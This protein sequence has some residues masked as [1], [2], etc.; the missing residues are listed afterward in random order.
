MSRIKEQNDFYFESKDASSG[1]LSDLKW[2]EGMP[3]LLSLAESV[4]TFVADALDEGAVAL[5]LPQSA[6]ALLVTEQLGWEATALL[7]ATDQHESQWLSLPEE[8]N[9]DG[10]GEGWTAGEG[11]GIWPDSWPLEGLK[12]TQDVQ[13]RRLDIPVTDKT[14]LTLLVITSDGKDKLRGL[15]WL[16][17]KV[18]VQ[19]VPLL[20]IW[21]HAR[22]LEGDLDQAQTQ[23]HALGRLNELQEKAVSLASHEFKTPL[24]SITAYS[25]AMR[26]Q[27]SNTEF[28]HAIE[29]LDVIRSEAGRLLRMVNRILDYSKM[30]AG[31]QLLPTQPLKICPLVEETLLALKPAAAAKKLHLDVKLPEGLP[32]VQGDDDLIRQVLIN[33]LGNAVKYTPAGGQVRVAAKENEATVAVTVL[34]TGVGIADQDLQK[35]FREFYRSRGRALSEDGTGLGLSIVRDIVNL[36][37]GFVQVSRRTEGGT[38]FAVNLPKEVRTPSALPLAFVKKVDGE[39]AR[40]LINVIV[41]LAAEL[42]E[43]RSVE[44]QLWNEHQQLVTVAAIGASLKGKPSWETPLGLEEQKLGMLRVGQPVGAECPNGPPPIQL[45]IVAQAVS[46]ALAHLVEGGLEQ[47]SSSTT[48]Q[49][50]KATEALR[51][52]L[53]IKRSGVP[54]SSAQAQKL[55]SG[56]GKALAMDAA[57]VD[58][59]QYAALL[60]DAGMARV[61]VEIVLGESELA[62][63]QRD[64]VERHVEQG[65]DL[66]SP[67]LPDATTLGIIYHH[68]EKVDGTGYPGGLIADEIPLGARVLA[69]IDAWFALTRTRTFRQGLSAVE[70]WQEIMKHSG[71]QFD[72]EVVRALG[73]VLSG[74]GVLPECPV[75]TS[76]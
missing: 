13:W 8:L 6:S 7:R 58:R 55:I 14:E 40:L 32:R 56:L 72:T 31:Q 35:I 59:L 69:V 30:S 62:W 34:D 57:D 3:D 73:G 67:L 52:I 51:A 16:L 46:R 65:V 28:P 39:Q 37:E 42:T 43:N 45:R 11:T 26:Q 64:E 76:S 24:T 29:F 15:E 17:E 33:V 9:L 21:V 18:R 66:M 4:V 23:I 36:H 27:I 49:V 44:I 38:S 48:L 41:Y 60:H 20:A 25:D 63:D 10:Q 2:H 71:T 22:H 50:T 75:K 68:H 54:T 19:L 12:N 61:E 5:V 1:L 74:E 47:G 53:Q 70:A